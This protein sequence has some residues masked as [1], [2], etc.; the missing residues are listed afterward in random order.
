V[1][2]LMAAFLE[3]IGDQAKAVL[4]LPRPLAAE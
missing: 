2:R 1:E 4:L 3:E